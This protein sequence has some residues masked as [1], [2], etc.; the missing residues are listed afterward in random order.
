MITLKKDDKVK[1]LDDNST[2]VPIL[3]ANGWKQEEEQKPVKRR[4]ENKK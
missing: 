1:K 4:R 3:K 2:L